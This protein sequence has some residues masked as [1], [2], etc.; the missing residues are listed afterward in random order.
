MEAGMG[1]PLAVI[2]TIQSAR[3]PSTKTQRATLIYMVSLWEMLAFQ[4]MNVSCCLS[5]PTHS[6]FLK[7]DLITVLDAL[8]NPPFKYMSQY[9]YYSSRFNIVLL[10]AQTFC[11][12]GQ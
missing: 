3:A 6:L 12:A 4:F 1:L 2:E 8:T 9:N 5:L 10:L 11:E 7:R